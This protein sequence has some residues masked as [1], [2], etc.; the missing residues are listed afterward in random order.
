MVYSE[1][2]YRNA[3][4]N[5][6][7]EFV[8]KKC[9]EIFFKTK[10]EIS[11]NKG[12]IPVFC[13]RN[14][15]KQFYKDECYITV[16]CENCGKEKRILKGDYNK[17][18]NKKFFCNHSCSAEY[19]N[20]KRARNS[21]KILEYND[22]KQ[23]KKCF[24]KEK[25]LESYN[26]GEKYIMKECKHHGLT[27]YVYVKSEKRYRCVK[28]RNNAVQKRRYNLKKILVEYKGG[29]CE[30]CGYNKCISALEFHHLNENEKDFGI[31]EK[32]YTRS[33]SK[34]KEEVD[35]CVLVC[36]NC[37]REIHDGIIEISPKNK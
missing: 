27:K 1:E 10:R 31:A 5:D 34:N 16:K 26:N 9:G 19:N 8:C 3:K 22:N 6:E 25:Q 24:D 7:F 11:K 2:N 28:C 20:K 13:S 35:K 21:D 18:E 23:T 32:G 33:I 17:S 15:Q 36:A 4:T 12:K 29:K 30:I 37:H 14:C